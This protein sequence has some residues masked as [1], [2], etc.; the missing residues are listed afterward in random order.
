MPNKP[1][2]IGMAW[3]EG[4]SFNIGVA[5]ITGTSI[6]TGSAS[7]GFKGHSDHAGIC[8]IRAAETSRTSTSFRN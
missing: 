7:K 5:C 4:K 3:L 1:H 8:S 6:T 2:G